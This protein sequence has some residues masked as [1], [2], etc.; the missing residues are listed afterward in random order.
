M[1]LISTL[2]WLVV[3][4]S[5]MKHG[6]L[7]RIALTFAGIA[8]FFHVIF[9]GV[10]AFAPELLLKAKPDQL[11]DS[12]RLIFFNQG[13]YNLF[14]AIGGAYGIFRA[15]RE[16]CVSALL[17]FVLLS[18]VGAALVLLFSNPSL[19]RGVLAQGVPPLLALSLFWFSGPGS[20]VG[21]R[22]S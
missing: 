7:N 2:L 15:A 10:E 1:F 9:F 6:L 21:G 17:Y 16:K 20:T 5:V 3:D 14:L 18:M 13:F 12:V 4:Y 19:L 8:C 22:I 11:N